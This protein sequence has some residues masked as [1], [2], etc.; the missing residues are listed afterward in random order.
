MY[1]NLCFHLH[2]FCGKY[3]YTLPLV[4]D[5]SLELQLI[6]HYIKLCKSQVGCEC[7]TNSPCSKESSLIPIR[8][9]SFTS[10]SKGGCFT[11]LLIS[12]QP[13]ALLHICC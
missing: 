11:V 1:R 5:V 12:S 4:G 6:N 2:L 7:A 3:L 10:Q 13:A 9:S 8:Y